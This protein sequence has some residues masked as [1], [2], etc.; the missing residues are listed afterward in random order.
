MNDLEESGDSNISDRPVPAL[1][2]CTSGKAMWASRNSAEQ[3][4]RRNTAKYG[5]VQYVYQCPEC[6]WFHTARRK[7]NGLPV[8]DLQALRRS[9]RKRGGKDG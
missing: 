9:R 6:D 3:Q 7:H 5:F 2:V 1:G 8:M 4:A